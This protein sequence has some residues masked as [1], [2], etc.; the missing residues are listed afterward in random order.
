MTWRDGRMVAWQFFKE[1]NLMLS[2]SQV[3]LTSWVRTINCCSIWRSIWEN[4]SIFNKLSLILIKVQNTF[5]LSSAVLQSLQPTSQHISLK[6]TFLWSFS[7]QRSWALAQWS[8]LSWLSCF[9]SPPSYSPQETKKSSLMKLHWTPLVQNLWFH[10]E[11]RSVSEKKNKIWGNI[12]WKS[13]HR[14]RPLVMEEVNCPRKKLSI[15]KYLQ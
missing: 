14:S 13:T 15:C 10:S 2:H 9:H 3:S 4:R 7:S 11:S 12:R 8:A 1:T 5:R 6:A